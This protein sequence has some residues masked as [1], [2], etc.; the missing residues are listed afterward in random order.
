MPIKVYTDDSKINDEMGSAMCSTANEA[1]TK[2]WKTKLSLANTVLQPEVLAIEWVNTANVEI[3]IC[4]DSESSLQA[5]KP[6]Y[7]KSKII[8]EA[9]ITLLGNGRIKLG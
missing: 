7:V 9:E 4:S 5:L 2:T 1:I 3:N 6:F 8:Q